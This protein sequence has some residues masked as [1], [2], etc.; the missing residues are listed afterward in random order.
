M[1][2]KFKQILEGKHRNHRM[3]EMGKSTAYI[4][5]HEVCTDK[6][7]TPDEKTDVIDKFCHD[8]YT[9]SDVAECFKS[10]VTFG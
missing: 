8:A 6:L 10:E 1:S 2:K 3:S 7:L 4:I 9:V 5:I